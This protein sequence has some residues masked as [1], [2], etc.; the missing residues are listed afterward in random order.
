MP[1][2]HFIVTKQVRRFCNAN[3]RRISPDFVVCLNALI[4]AKLTAACAVH[5]GGKITLDASVAAHVGI[6]Y[7]S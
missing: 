3:G 1:E 4:R 6:H 5:N 2:N 7:Q